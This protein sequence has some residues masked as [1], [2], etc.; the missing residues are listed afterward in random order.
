MITSLLKQKISKP[1]MRRIGQGFSNIVDVTRWGAVG[2]LRVH[3]KWECSTVGLTK[4][5][6]SF[7]GFRGLRCHGCGDCCGFYSRQIHQT[8]TVALIY[9]RS[10]HWIYNMYALCSD[11]IISLVS[12]GT[13]S[14]WFICKI[15]SSALFFFIFQRYKET[16]LYFMAT[17]KVTQA[18]Y[19]IPLI[20]GY[21]S[22]I[23]YQTSQNF[24]SWSNPYHEL[25]LS[26]I[27]WSLHSSGLPAFY[28]TFQNLLATCP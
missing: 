8:Q 7:R 12:L 13:L 14:I 9:T 19:F 1:I 15:I 26:M 28:V 25:R 20:C 22:L 21:F 16:N 5:C 4:S 3:D 17:L 24:L 2:T 23:R 6:S 11:Q 18:V 27:L 10:V